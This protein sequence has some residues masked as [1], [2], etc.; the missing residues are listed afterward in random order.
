[1]AQNSK[2]ALPHKHYVRIWIAILILSVI[3]IGFTFFYGNWVFAEYD[4]YSCFALRLR[5]ATGHGYTFDCN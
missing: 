2:T 1:M 3:T 4:G 5:L